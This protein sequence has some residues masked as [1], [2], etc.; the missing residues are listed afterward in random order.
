M[1]NRKHVKA[2]WWKRKYVRRFPNCIE[3]LAASFVGVILFDFKKQ[4][5]RNKN[6]LKLA[7]IA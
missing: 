5:R 6:Q 7:C 4:K 1:L 3:I 2:K